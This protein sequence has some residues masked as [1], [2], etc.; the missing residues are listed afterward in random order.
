MSNIDYSARIHS[1]PGAKRYYRQTGTSTPQPVYTD[2]GLTVAHSNPVVAD[3][4]GYFDVIYL[5]PALP[6]Y[7]VIHTDGSN[8]DDDYTMEVLLEPILDDIPAAQLESQ[9]YR[10]K[11]AAPELIFEETDAASNEGKWKLRAQGGVFLIS[12]LDDAESVGED[13]LRIERNGTAMSVFE[14]NGQPVYEVSSFTGTLTG[15]TTTPTATIA[16]ARSGPMVSLTCNAGLSGTSNTNAM[17]VTGLPAAL[18]PSLSQTIITRVNDNGTPSLAVVS[19]SAVN[20]VMSFGLGIAGAPT[21]FTTSGTK[22]LGG[23]WQV[24]YFV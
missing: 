13:I 8:V 3:A 19:I 5:D 16:Y 1:Q 20:G 21:G 10:L 12:T 14:I 2:I 6:N 22:G 24:I 15:C 18:W 9:T 17:T 7:R 4:D 11:A 23:N